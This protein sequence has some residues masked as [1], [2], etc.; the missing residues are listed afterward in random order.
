[1]NQLFRLLTVAVLLGGTV[2]CR[3]MVAN[4]VDVSPRKEPTVSIKNSGLDSDVTIKSAVANYVGEKMEVVVILENQDSSDHAIEYV[5]KWFEESKFIMNKDQPWITEFVV[6][7][8]EK[9]LKLISPGAG[10]T[11]CKVLIRYGKTD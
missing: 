7:G 8:E 10:A 1:M 6:A 4:T 9:Q 2:G 11:N 5:A 3:S